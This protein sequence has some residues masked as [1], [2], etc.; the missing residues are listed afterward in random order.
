VA[1]AAGLV[2]R[3]ARSHRL[4]LS[5]AFATILLATTLLSAVAIYTGSVADNALYA[6]VRAVPVTHTGA[7][8]TGSLRPDRV[9]EQDRAVRDAVAAAYPGM[10]VHVTASGLSGS[11]GLP[12][13]AAGDD[14]L[15]VF[16]FYDDLPAHARLTSGRWP[17][18][19]S[20]PEPAAPGRQPV[21]AVEAV[22]PQPAAT[23]L[24]LAADDRVRVKNRLTGAAVD[25]HVVGSYV[26][27][28]PG[29]AFWFGHELETSGRSR[30]TSF[31]TLGPLVTG[32]EAFLTR[33]PEAGTSTGRWRVAPLLD[34]LAAA[35]IDGVA[36]GVRGL[37]ARLAEQRLFSDTVGDT[38]SVSTGL[39]ALLDRVA[40]ALVVAR[41][42]ILIPV[43][44]L[45]LLAGYA[46][47]LTARLL[48]EHRHVETAL[49]RARGATTRQLM[50]LSLREGLLLTLPA[51]LL[52]P[53]LAA[54]VLQ[55]VDRA[56][57]LASAGIR[58]DASPTP[59]T[60]LVAGAAALAC[61]LALV[62]AAGSGAGSY[63]ES[64]QARGRP[65]RRG[66]LQRAG[67][68]LLLLAVAAL[69]YWQLRRYR[70]PVLADA[71]GGL[72][73]DPL[74]VVGPALALLAL[75]V[76]T[77]RLLPV[78]VRVAE[79]V[80][81]RTTFTPALGTW[82]V[83][84][85][86]ARYAGPAL[87]L[88]MAL[89]IGTLSAGYSASWRRSQGDQAAFRVGADLRVT[90]PPAVRDT[91][92]LAAR[93]AD[94]PGVR[95]A[96]PLARERVRVAGEPAELLALDSARAAGV[97]AVRPDLTGGGTPE[98][99]LAALHTGRSQLPAV[100]LP[101]RPRV[102]EVVAS[103]R[104]SRPGRS[105]LPRD[106]LSAGVREADMV[107]AVRD[108]NGVIRRL[109]AGGLRADGR[110]H[111][112][113]VAL[114]PAEGEPAWPLEVVGLE[115]SYQAPLVQRVLTFV[116]DQLRPVRP[117]GSP[118]TVEPDGGW[119][120]AV[121]DESEL[122]IAPRVRSVDRPRGG[123]FAVTVASGAGA[124]FE[125]DVR[126][127]AWP[128]ALP[129]QAAALPALVSERALDASGAGLGDVVAVEL[130]GDP[131]QVRVAGA[132]SELPTVGPDKGAVL[133]DLPSLA[134]LLYQRGDLLTPD[135]FLL[136]TAGD[137]GPAA[138]ALRADPGS[139]GTVLDRVALGRELRE[140]PLAAGVL[141]A[142]AMSFAA[143]AAFAGVGFAV[144]AVVSARERAAEFAVLR[145][146]GVSPR[147]LV[148]LIG[149]EQAYLVVLGLLVGLVLGAAVAALVVPL[150]LLTAE[151]ARVVPP[152][153]VS[154]P[155]VTVLGLVAALVAV[156][157]AIVLVLAHYLR[158]TALGGTLRAGEDA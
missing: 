115:V 21:P 73:A 13:P 58:L 96:L 45:V 51:A 49:L 15:T 32:R 123:V 132:L 106:E 122:E 42:T 133:V 151:A 150:V 155:W 8:I 91:A 63:V 37:G 77:L 40:R 29:A 88:V 125:R 136:D 138:A 6:A 145:A 52:G 126:L 84:R 68:D 78:L 16:G 117:G 70:S 140:D 39:P 12:Q 156:L 149:V 4:I 65:S 57:P 14:T 71:G 157:A 82:Q 116:V 92:G 139:A 98:E 54:L 102:L 141:G 108:G 81:G 129:A 119:A 55:A 97:F 3:R 100:E 64:Q 74:L 144:N 105:R 142:L 86:P 87:L 104:N 120:V 152:V 31:T 118:V 85:R 2:A 127:G 80:S 28:D 75:A 111:R 35:E 83:S 46:L 19:G 7:E 112:L 67:V 66:L 11:Y 17:T 147:Q 47:L 143:A 27:R 107:V 25:V 60:W 34:E 20:E 128:G 110:P 24:G 90:A 72:G 137:T 62:L 50:G 109:S 79:R 33:L 158:G 5:A 153:L 101:G 1:A 10:T 99:L 93:Y 26:P 148:G 135:E 38:T 103:L 130:A 22:L 134:A 61:A 124:P 95:T 48:S 94:L 41:S 53:P 113:R 43:A 76:L 114:L 36:A 69:A 9:G 23:A 154:I 131:V 121:L 89:A 59:A 18:P 44:Q 30:S 56:G 146:L